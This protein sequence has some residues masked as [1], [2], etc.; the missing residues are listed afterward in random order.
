MEVVRKAVERMLLMDQVQLGLQA[1]P[2]SSRMG[3]HKAHSLCDGKLDGGFGWEHHK[4]FDFMASGS[5]FI[6]GPSLTS[7]P[8]PPLVL[9]EHH[10]GLTDSFS[11]QELPPHHVVHAL[12]SCTGNQETRTTSSGPLQDNQCGSLCPQLNSLRFNAAL[13]NH[14]IFLILKL[15]MKKDSNKSGTDGEMYMQLF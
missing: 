1:S 3:S 14:L 8:H 11:K 5:R 10:K 7:F 2:A 12:I 13:K 4:G 15:T 9:P 6:L